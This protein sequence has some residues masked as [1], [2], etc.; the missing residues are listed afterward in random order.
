MSFTYYE[1]ADLTYVEQRGVLTYQK[2]DFLEAEVEG[3]FHVHPISRQVVARKPMG[4]RKW[5][6]CNEPDVVK[7]MIRV[8][9]EA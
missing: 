7:F 1:Y 8:E 6:V 3:W 9:E 4:S 5:H 2:S